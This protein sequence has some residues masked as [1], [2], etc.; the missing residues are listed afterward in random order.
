MKRRAL[1][2]FAVA[3]VALAACQNPAH[4]V[5]PVADITLDGALQDIANGL[6]HMKQ[7][8]DLNKD[9]ASQQSPLYGS[10]VDEVD[11]TFQLAATGSS[12]KGA[13]VAIGAPPAAPITANLGVSLQN[14]ETGNRGSTIQIKV[15]S[16][17]TAPLN[18][19]GCYFYMQGEYKAAGAAAAAK[20]CVSSG[21]Q[22]Q[23]GTTTQS[24]AR[25][26]VGKYAASKLQKDLDALG[27]RMMVTEAD[28]R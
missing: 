25:D 20:G 5:A 4:T 9:N 17:G 21:G 2:P 22:K 6:A 24:D 18:F 27:A 28:I 23:G 1:G 19:M 13:T 11:I 10:I 12:T 15:R 14:V 3:L 16:A 7:T 8:V 26:A